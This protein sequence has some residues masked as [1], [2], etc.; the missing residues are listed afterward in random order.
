MLR[1]LAVFFFLGAQMCT[2]AQLRSVRKNTNKLKAKGG[3]E[4]P[5]EPLEPLEPPLTIVW[6]GSDLGVTRWSDVIECGDKWKQNNPKQNNPSCI[7]NGLFGMA[8]WGGYN[9]PT[10]ILEKAFPRMKGAQGQGTFIYNDAMCNILFNPERNDYITAVSFNSTH[11]RIWM[12][13][14]LGTNDQENAAPASA[15]LAS[16]L[17][18]QCQPQK[19]RHPPE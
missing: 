2:A 11:Y 4:E 9:V 5:T 7:G 19:T 16:A 10:D 3:I 1:F 17:K 6:N 8:G 18:K 12:G 15:L 13:C 14:G